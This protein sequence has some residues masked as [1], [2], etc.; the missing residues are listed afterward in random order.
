MKILV[1]RN[2]KTNPMRRVLEILLV[3]L[4]LLGCAIASEQ[5]TNTELLVIDV[6]SVKASNLND[7]KDFAGWAQHLRDGKAS[8]TRFPKILHAGYPL[9]EA[10]HIAKEAQPEADSPKVVVAGHVAPRAGQGAY[11][12]TFSEL[13]RPPAYSGQTSLTLRP[14]ERRVLRLPPIDFGQSA[15]LETVVLIQYKTRDQDDSEKSRFEIN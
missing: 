6:Y 5:Q 14:Q 4:L 10:F 2:E 12:I 7:Q 3:Q 1:P 13:G 8:L 11:R 9:G 15:M